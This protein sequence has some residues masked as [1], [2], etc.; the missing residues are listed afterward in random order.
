M[1]T[2]IS[3][4]ERLLRAAKRLAAQRGSTLSEVIADALRAQLAAKPARPNRAFQLVVFKGDGPREG[5]DLDHT[6]ELDVIDD[7]L[8]YGEVRGARR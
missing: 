1:R 2:T 8:R 3:L 4:D 5:I 6:S 7:V